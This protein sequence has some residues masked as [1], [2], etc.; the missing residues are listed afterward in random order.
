MLIACHQLANG[1]GVVLI[2]DPPPVEHLL[3]PAGDRRSLVCG[4]VQ[5]LS[6]EGVTIRVKP[7]SWYAF[8]KQTRQQPDRDDHPRLHTSVLTHPRTQ[9]R[10]Q[11]RAYRRLRAR[12][13]ECEHAAG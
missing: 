3:L 10:G 12:A 2:A 6:V 4:D 8:G 13:V 1:V 11:D 5:P 9:C 7:D